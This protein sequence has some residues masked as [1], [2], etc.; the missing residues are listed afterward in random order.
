MWVSTLRPGLLISPASV[1]VLPP[2]SPYGIRT[3]DTHATHLVFPWMLGIS[4]QDFMLVKQGLLY[5]ES[6]S[7]L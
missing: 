2:I 7:A 1:S 6:S 3:T 5:T 4:A